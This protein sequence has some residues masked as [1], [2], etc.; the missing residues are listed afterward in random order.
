LN[1]GAYDYLIKP[2]SSEE[3]VL[4]L[5]W[6]M[7]KRWLRGLLTIKEQHAVPQLKARQAFALIITRCPKV[8]RL[9]KEAELHARSDMSVLIG[10]ESVT[11][12]ELLARAI[13][14]AS[15]RA[16]HPFTP[17]NMAALTSELFDAEFFGHAKGA[18]AGAEK[19]RRG[20]LKNIQGARCFWMKSVICPSPDK[21]T[22]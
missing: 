9:L 22:C 20:Y 11:D 13:H 16:D 2:V 19:D 12:K 3:L 14:D 1:K 7:E 10:G 21:P 6:A 17:V 15:P 4:T 18:F 8:L 5:H